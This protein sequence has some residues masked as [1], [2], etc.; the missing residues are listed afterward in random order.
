[1]AKPNRNPDVDAWFDALDRRQAELK[2][3]RSILLAT[4][5][6]EEYKWRAPCYT[7][8]GANVAIIH[9]FNEYSAIGFFKGV[10]LKDPTKILEAPGPNS[11]SSRIAKF[12]SAKDITAKRAALEGLVKE[13]IANEIAGRDVD[14]SERD[15]IEVPAELKAIFEKDPAYEKAFEALTPGRRRGYLIHFSSAKQSKTRTARIEKYRDKIFAGKG[16][17]EHR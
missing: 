9:D 15:D 8:E 14:F 16:M 13:A 3:L 10:L 1:M 4:P 7:Y 5:L 6:T 11:R 17:Q 12:T 2:R